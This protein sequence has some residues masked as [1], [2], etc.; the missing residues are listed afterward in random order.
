MVLVS[1]VPVSIGGIYKGGDRGIINALDAATGE[2]RW[3]FDTVL[4]DDLW[5]NPE[6]N[7]GGGAWYPPSIDTEQ[8]LVLLGHRQPGAL[9]GHAGVPQRLEPAGRQPLHRLRGRP[10]RRDR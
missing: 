5:G 10:R 7:S 3:T 8:G 4:G 6:V 1:T 2:V 9:P